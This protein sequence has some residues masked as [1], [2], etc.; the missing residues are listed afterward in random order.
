MAGGMV[1]LG[2]MLMT[3]LAPTAVVVIHACTQLASNTTRAYA[4]H[5]NIRWRSIVPYV[6]CA[7]P[8]PLLGLWLLR[9]LQPDQ[10]RACM[11]GLILYVVWVPKWGMT[12][13]PER[14]AFGLAGTVA[15]T[16]GVVV[17]A[18]GP[19]IAP[20]FLRADFR[21]EQIIATKAV[22]QGTAHIIKL[23]ALG[24]LYPGWI[25]APPTDFDVVSHLPLIVPMVLVSV[26][27]TYIGKWLLGRF[28]ERAFRRLY[29]SILTILALRL[30]LAVL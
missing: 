28:T 9:V 12:L 24:G 16:L 11:A 30:L 17:G 2:L 8:G 3:D 5:P 6:V 14:V 26:A 1:L 21:K 23:V 13:L 18:V 19:L 25:A 10:V 4:H 20:F 15:G 7:L 29:K 22:C 27:G